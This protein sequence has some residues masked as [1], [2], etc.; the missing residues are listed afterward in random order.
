MRPVPSILLAQNDP[1]IQRMYATALENEG[2]RVQVTADGAQALAVARQGSVDVI[3][4]GIRL[5]G[6]LRSGPEVLGALKADDR[7]QSIPV[8]I[9]TNVNSSDLV[10][11][12]L[13]RG[14]TDYLVLS[15][16][17]PK[18]LAT[19]VETLASG[20]VGAGGN[21]RQTSPPVTPVDQPGIAAMVLSSLQESLGVDHE[22]SVRTESRLDWW[23]HFYRQTIAVDDIFEDSGV[24]LTPISCRTEILES[25]P[26]SPELYAALSRVN[27]LAS[28]AALVYDRPN[29]VVSCASRV[30]LHPGTLWLKSVLQA[31][32]AI[33]IHR[34][35]SLGPYW[36]K[37]LRGRF[38]RSPHPSSGIRAQPD[39]VV[40][41]VESL[42][43]PAGRL[44]S[45]FS[46]LI[47]D[48]DRIPHPW[49]TLERTHGRLVAEVAFRDDV[50]RAQRIARNQAIGTAL[51][52]ASTDEKHPDLGHGLA[53][54]LELPIPVDPSGRAA[55][56]ANGL[57]FFETS[58]E[59]PVQALGSWHAE[60]ML[61]YRTFLPAL[62]ANSH[63]RSS[64]VRL[65]HTFL[66][67]LAHR[68]TR[69]RHLLDTA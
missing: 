26:E 59:I 50:P 49:T 7:T 42:F 60:G 63:D 38:A 43:E 37:Q 9:L 29:G 16:T 8:V 27:A 32:A 68:S 19:L 56:I 45:P 51:L 4:L 15:R 41:I 54:S 12:C 17:S 62:L 28:L 46:G 67:Y 31:A 64:M 55:A 52:I 30:L 2:C 65:I 35:E 69:V 53:V 22:W 5:N 66:L 47:D 1:V 44:E 13:D 14:A 23:P 6:S 58:G 11:E 34:V 3:V 24:A 57:N 25:I 20:S 40:G 39:A 48:V 33:Q 61:R 18:Q 21:R 10:K 36:E